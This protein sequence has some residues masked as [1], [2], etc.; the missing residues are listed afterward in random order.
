MLFIPY[1]W[2]I[3]FFY[4]A[5]EASVETEPKFSP[6]TG[7]A[8]R[9]DGKP[10]TYQPPPVPS[11]G[12]K[13]KQPA[14]SN[15]TGQPSAGSTSQNA[16]RQS[17]GKLVFGSNASLHPKETQKVLLF[18]LPSFFWISLLSIITQFYKQNFYKLLSNM[19]LVPCSR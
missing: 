17:Q 16:A 3:S 8:R 12:S 10:L 15:G 2:S 9:L 11:L 7:V 4:V 18:Y 19:F 6:F 14:T 5:E 13:D 1:K